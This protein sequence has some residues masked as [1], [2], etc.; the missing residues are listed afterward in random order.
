MRYMGSKNRISKHIAPILKAHRKEG[1]AY[2]EPFVGGANMIDKM[3]GWRIGADSH[4]YLMAFWKAFVLGWEP[5]QSFTEEQ[6]NHVKLNRDEDKVLS[7]YIGFCLS[8]GGK[9]FGGWSRDKQNSDY[10]DR[11]YRHMMKQRP[12]VVGVQFVHTSYEGLYIPSN[13]LVYCDPPYANTTK[14]RDDFDHKAF[15][16]WVVTLAKSGHTVFVSEYTA[17]DFAEVVWQ[18][19]ISVNFSVQ[20]DGKRNVE[21]LFKVVDGEHLPNVGTITLANKPK[22]EHFLSTMSGLGVEMETDG[23]LI[24]A[25]DEVTVVDSEPVAPIETFGD[26]PKLK[27]SAE[28]APVET[29]KNSTFKKP[30]KSCIDKPKTTMPPLP[31]KL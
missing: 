14:Y 26:K 15:W 28:K 2:V 19:D 4:E 7:G 25:S 13:S 29:T 6:Y 8:F 31:S 18:K 24:D 22:T 17:P 23:K 20:A 5:P 10:A 9:W 27:Q 30:E 16:D 12:K 3:D 21:C 1:Q 11:A